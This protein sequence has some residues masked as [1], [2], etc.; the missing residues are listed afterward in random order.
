MRAASAKVSAKRPK[1][2][3]PRGEVVVRRV[4][5]VTLEHLA[6]DGFARLSVPDVALAAGVNKTSVYRRW[7]TKA[8][9]VRDALSSSLGHG[10]APP[11]T[12]S[13]RGDMLGLAR[14]ALVF[15]ESP[16][17]AGVLRTLL[18][19]GANRELRAMA[20]SIFRAQ[21]SANPRLVLQRAVA[22]GELP[23]DVDV[24]LVLTT[25]AGAL[26]HRVLIEHARVTD[27]FLEGL[28][29]LV[30]GGVRRVTAT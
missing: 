9:L 1:A 3:Q 12:G 24:K 8:D 6:R 11:D 22:R 17:G 4:L 15:V 14:A 29:D 16:T 27:D 28:I 13:L 21:E 20:E 19:E 30:L 10:E 26:M 7:P 2:K 23:A 25:V 5:T 18:A